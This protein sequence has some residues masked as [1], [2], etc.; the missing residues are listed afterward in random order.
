MINTFIG[1]EK[2]KYEQDASDEES[3]ISERESKP[4]V[5]KRTRQKPEKPAETPIRSISSSSSNNIKLIKRP[6]SSQKL[7]PPP[8][9][10]DTPSTRNLALKGFINT[11]T[12][13]FEQIQRH[14][15]EFETISS[16]IDT[17]QPSVFAQEM[18]NA[19]F[20]ATCLL[21]P[22]GSKDCGPNV[23]FFLNT[24]IHIYIYIYIYSS[25]PLVQGK[26]SNFT[27]QFKRQEKHSSKTKVTRG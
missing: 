4:P 12:M 26:I 10:L 7:K 8:E 27:V 9:Q 3:D 14:P 23:S 5:E 22:D 18:E 20:E 15:E 24:Y 1:L 16:Q 13:L 11:F 19:L 21:K 25:F 17:S 6:L 2:R